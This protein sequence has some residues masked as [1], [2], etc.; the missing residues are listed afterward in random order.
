[1]DYGIG[2]YPYVTLTEA[3]QT[4]FE[5]RKLSRTEA[6]PKALNTAPSF[7]EAFAKI[8][9]VRRAMWKP[10]SRTEE[11]W[12]KELTVDAFPHTGKKRVNEVMT[13][14]VM[15]RLLADHLWTVNPSSPS[16]AASGSGRS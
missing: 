11:Q 2:S 6:D 16:V 12:R 7:E 14:D 10:S 13:T 9:A 15:P 1:M 3:C 8:L 4:A 5:Y